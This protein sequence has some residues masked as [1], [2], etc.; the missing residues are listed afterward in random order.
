MKS[1]KRLAGRE[2]D[3]RIYLATEE[4]QVQDSTQRKWPQRQRNMHKLPGLRDFR[5]RGPVAEVH[6]CT[7][8][9]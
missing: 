8:K 5:A 9:V 6:K 1:M 2:S 7:F 3:P 4:P